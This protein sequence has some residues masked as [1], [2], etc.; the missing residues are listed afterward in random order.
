MAAGLSH[1]FQGCV[2]RVSIKPEK[3]VHV[4][5]Q[6][7][8]PPGASRDSQGGARGQQ[9]GHDHAEPSGFPG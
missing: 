4:V 9:A 8:P 6:L 5:A 2:F 7:L 3:L 1:A